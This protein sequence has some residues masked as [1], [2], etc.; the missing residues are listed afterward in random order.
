[1]N[2]LR[3]TL[4][5]AL[6]SASATLLGWSFTPLG[7]ASSKEAK[8]NKRGESNTIGLASIA[9]ASARTDP[10][11][12]QSMPAKLLQGI[13]SAKARAGR[14]TAN[15]AN[16]V[17]V[18]N[19]VQSATPNSQSN[20]SQATASNNPKVLM[21]VKSGRSFDGD[22]RDLPRTKPTKVRRERPEREAPDEGVYLA[23]ENA[24]IGAG[25]S[26]QISAPAPTPSA[27]FDGIH[28]TESC[29]GGQCGGG[30]P[31]DPN[32]DVGPTY[33]IQTVNTAI[34]IYNKSTGTRVAGF[35]YDNFMSQGNFGNLCDTDN[36]GD[37]VVLYDTFTD[38][39]IITDF[40]FILNSDGS[41]ASPPGA[42]QCFA[43]SK[44]GD[45]VAGGWNFYS[46]NITDALNDYPKFGIWSDGLYMSANMFGFPANGSFNNVRVWAFNKAQMYAGAP[47][48]QSV[49]FNAPA[50]VQGVSVFTMLPSN[51]R[52]QV[53]P[54]PAG[55]E[56]LFASVWGLIDRV[57]VWKFHVDWTNPASSTFTGPSDSITSTTWSSA[58][59]FVPEKDGNTLDTLA[60]RLMVQNQYS[61]IGGVES[62]WNSHT[63]AGSSSSQSAVRWYQVGVTGGTVAAN[64]TQAATWN[65]DSK[66]RFV[67]SAAVDRLGDMA[68]GYSVSDSTIDPAIR[69]AGRLA[70]DP[71]NTLS[72]TETSLIEGTGGQT[73]IFSDG[74]LDQRW[75]DYSSM[76]LDPDGCTFW[77]TNEYYVTNGADDHT[78]IGSFKFSQC[79]PA[80]NGTLQGTVRK[81][82]DNTPISGATVTIGSDT[83]TTDTNGFYSFA[84]Y[85]VGTY[86]VT[87]VA[88]GYSPSTVNGVV[89]TQNTTTTQNFSLTAAPASACLIDTT[90][91]DFDAGTATNV[92]TATSPGDLKLT[93]LSGG[94]T[95]D[96]QQTQTSGFALNTDYEAQ[97]FK[98]GL[99][100]QLTKA[101]VF[102][103]TNTATPITV[104]IYNTSGG[105]PTGSA[106]ASTT[107][108]PSATAQFFA[109][110]FSSPA[111]VTAGTTYALVL[112]RSGGSS[113]IVCSNGGN[114]CTSTY[115]NGNAYTSTNGTTWTVSPTKQTAFMT[116]VSSSSG[117]ASSGNLV[118]SLKDANPAGNA[119]ANW[120]TLSWTNSAL[121]AGTTLQ[122]Q[123]AG[124]TSSSGPFNFVGP[125]GTSG[126]FF[127]TSGASL[128]QFNGFRYL[129]YKAY[130]STSNSANTPT[131]NDVTVC[132]NN[133]AL[134]STSLAASA[135]SGPYGG[136]TNLSAMLTSGGNGVNGETI[137]FTLNGSPV[138]SATTNASG[139]ASLS[140]VSLS[141]INAGTYATG[142]AAS[143]A[144]DATYASTGGTN[145]LAVNKADQTISV[146]T[147]APLTAVYN[148]QFTVAATAGSGLSVSYSAS[149]VCTNVGATFTMTSGTGT[150]TVQYDQSGDDNYKA[151]PQ[152]TES[153]TA[154]KVTQTINFTLGSSVAE[155]AGSVALNGTATSGLTVTY[156][157]SNTA[158]ATISGSTLNLVAPGSV[159]VTASQT[160][161]SNYS[162]ATP[163][164]QTTVVTG[165]IAGNDSVTR[166]ADSS[167]LNIPTATLL[168]N[169]SRIASDGSTQTDGLSITAVTAGAGDSV[170]LSGGNVVFTPDSPAS[171]AL[172]T[173]TYTVSD[174]SSTAVG[175]VTV[176]TSA[177]PPLTLQLVNFSAPTYNSGTNSTSI[178]VNFTGVANQ[179]YAIEYSTNMATWISA[180]APVSTTS[181]GS[182]QVTITASDDQTVAWTDGMFF[183]AI[184]QGPF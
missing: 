65:P 125:N 86:N 93:L 154:S 17:L 108:S 87:A 109:A 116:Y 124:S 74:S 33:Y 173:F 50:K 143:F 19:G 57:R 157:S 158:V 147:H 182:F 45:P 129:K 166:P 146:G 111:S 21:L 73:Q 44:T 132:Y 107:I 11:G 69:Y 177:G 37:P 128:S 126:T 13:I 115:A 133:A 38:R 34:G 141:G 114:N 56:N 163:V 58:P 165:P 5:I 64:A 164:N 119:V 167:S 59:S 169:D 84:S 62:L 22:V 159:T 30:H 138:G 14:S 151:A 152:V 10:G 39:W 76:S 20:E 6:V 77:Y 100:G 47:T 134:L 179:T 156:G 168:A 66:N 40:A 42:Y 85:P 106:I 35:T 135:A 92:D 81:A 46:I 12:P 29:T 144:G 96:Q 75:G 53:G 88:P 150:C 162:A 41:I 127:T 137:S 170:Q 18:S 184:V 55:R 49:S 94:E 8:S 52:A 122:F 161:D 7:D 117:Y 120:T 112:F 16:T 2:R 183:R 103:S 123:V 118:S 48:A 172:L 139:V 24:P 71:V 31:P 1:M 145:S 136:T 51:A 160:G 72:Q 54:P 131:L 110:T 80:A 4:S 15:G 174:G 130:L 155:S 178:T 70:T 61:N 180:G 171:N 43:A 149:G 82:S 63:V 99:T 36:F 104:G 28:F 102:L 140:N 95:L 26:S 113:W 91:A 78:R 32:G 25:V 105:A 83:A 98:A 90:K 89:V 67:P 79:T 9:L 176:P 23:G 142:V 175:T 60:T 68:I 3:I 101:E 181:T 121:P 148:S 27:S 153:V 97:T